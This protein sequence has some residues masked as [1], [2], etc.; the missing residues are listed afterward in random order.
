MFRNRPKAVQMGQVQ[1]MVES[2]MINTVALAELQTAPLNQHHPC[3]SFLDLC[4][5]NVTR[6]LDRTQSK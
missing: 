4:I 1:L 6:L 2:A 3:E 5:I